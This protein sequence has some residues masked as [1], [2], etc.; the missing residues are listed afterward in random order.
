[1]IDWVPGTKKRAGSDSPMSGEGRRILN[2]NLKLNLKLN[3]VGM[4]E[5]LKMEGRKLSENW[6]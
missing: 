5:M 2:L 6:G 1:M 4:G 3:G